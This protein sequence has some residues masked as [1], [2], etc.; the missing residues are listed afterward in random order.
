MAG[1]THRPPQ[2][3]SLGGPHAEALIEGHDVRIAQEIDVR[4]LTESIEHTGHQLLTDALPLEVGK[5]LQQRNEAA[6]HAVSERG[7]KSDDLATL[8]GDSEH[9]IIAAAKQAQVCL[10]RRR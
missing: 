8:H 1:L 10:R 3:H 7:D 6:E 9:D 5:Y 2:H 4:K